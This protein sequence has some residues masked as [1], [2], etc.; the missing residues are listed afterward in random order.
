MIN[1]DK[2]KNHSSKNKASDGSVTKTN[3]G[4]SS[5]N[6]ESQVKIAI[7]DSGIDAENDINLAY[8]VSLVPGEE[9]MTQVFMDG[10]GNFIGCLWIYCRCKCVQF[11]I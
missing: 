7:L 11:S 9:E 4:T 8:Q 1:A 6:T 2:V 3:L 5:T 10:N